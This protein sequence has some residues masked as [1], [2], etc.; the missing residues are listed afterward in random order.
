MRA[1]R[2][3]FPSV[4]S[5]E[6]AWKGE[7]RRGYLSRVI[8]GDRGDRIEPA[9]I[10]ALALREGR[11]AEWLWTGEGPRHP[12]RAPTQKAVDET[13]RKAEDLRNS[14]EQHPAPLEALQQGGERPSIR[15]RI[16]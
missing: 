12:V 14:A 9:E 7:E 10:S 8:S 5:A 4:R 13:E 16:R 1:A 6:R 2:R 15:R 3:G 11:Q